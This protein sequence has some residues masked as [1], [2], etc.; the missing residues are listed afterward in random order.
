MRILA[1][2]KIVERVAA[3]CQET[4]R[5]L[6]DDVLKALTQAATREASETGRAILD[7]ILDNARIARTEQLPLCQDTGLAVFFVDVGEEVRVEPDGLVSAI[8]EGVRRGY[9]EGYLRKSVVADPLRRE[10]TKDNTPAIVH[11]NLVRGDRVRIRFL[12]K[13]GGAE[14]MSRLAMLA[15]AHGREGVMEF[16]V[17]TAQLGGANACPPIVVGVGVGGNFELAPLLAKR[18]LLRPISERH[19][20]PFWAEFERE[21]LARINELGIGP[22][23]LGGTITCLDVHVEVHP[24]HIAS[25]PVAV[26]IECHSHRHAEVIL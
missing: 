10:N 7:Q 9:E 25:L 12:A 26:N 17:E 15:P 1:Y 3:I 20:D 21:A 5:N 6:P 22:Q 2:N 23:G 16:V 8:Q 24:C 4:N 18:A 19:S 14:N 11:V 13:G